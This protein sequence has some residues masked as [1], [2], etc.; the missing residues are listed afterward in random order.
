MGD[1]REGE[2]RWLCRKR[3]LIEVGQRADGEEG[4]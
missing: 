3:R 4:G 1:Q 2:G